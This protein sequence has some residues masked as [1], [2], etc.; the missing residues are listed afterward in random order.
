MNRKKLVLASVAFL[1]LAASLLAAVSAVP[2]IRQLGGNADISSVIPDSLIPERKDGKLSKFGS[3]EEFRK[4]LAEARE[5]QA[6][7]F[8][9]MGGITTREMS[10]MSSDMMTSSK[11]MP[12]VAQNTG[13]AGSVERISGTNVQVAGID[14]PDIV[15]T[16]GASIYFSREP[17][18]DSD[19]SPMPMME[20][21]AAAEMEISMLAP[22]EMMPDV[23]PYRYVPKGRTDIVAALPAD[24]LSK[25]GSLGRSGEMLLFGET[26]VVFDVSRRDIVAFDI[27][28]K[29]DPKEKWMVRN[30]D[31]TELVAA[32][33][34]E[35]MLYLVEKTWANES[36]P[37]PIMP[38]SLGSERISIACTDIYRPAV[39]SGADAVFTAL[40]IDVETGKTKEKTSFVGS[41]GQST[42]YMSENAVYATY[43]K[44]GDRIRY[45]LGFFRE[46]RD[47]LPAGIF[48][49]IEKL[50]DYD[51]GS[52]AKMTELSEILSKL[53][54]GQDQDEQLRF[55][56]EMR[57]R[58]TD[59]AKAHL[60]E[61]ESTGIA[62]LSLPDLSVVADGS[63]PGSLLNQFSLD[64]YQGNL[65][66]ATTVGGRSAFSFGWGGGRE[67]SANDVYVLDADLDREGA[68]LDLG[69]G[70]RIYAARFIGETGYLVTFRETDP[71]YVL[72][73]SDPD[74]PRKAG[75]LKIPGYSS[76][77][78]PLG[79]EMILGIG[80]EEGKVKLSLFDVSLPD[81]P[82]EIS[83][84]LLDEYWSEATQNHHAFLADP[85]HGIFFIP[86][87]QGG[88]VFSYEGN[89]LSLAKAAKD[90]R[91]KRALFIGDV[92]YIV[93]EDTIYSFDEN[94]WEKKGQLDL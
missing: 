93:S 5:S 72:D 91:I 35:N 71:F 25:I 30:G 47:L 36:Q 67:T 92:F 82:R 27:S 58:M 65:R 85:E 11:A 41:S 16:D 4:Y 70:E 32:R 90:D 94:T 88:Y 31:S 49:R 34:Y 77:L 19:E 7:G 62:K 74:E 60:R 17:S 89:E 53:S 83:K 13:G 63:V 28:D 14:E 81:E 43:P 24:T 86:G 50:A 59:Y 42:V 12:S 54:L 73:L 1:V 29:T 68:L 6:S 37:C 18:Y 75:E 8:G 69:L 61:L 84:Y 64:E 48:E 44:Q 39:P 51:I 52:G 10:V 57:N 46:N 21:R 87:S 80:N 78:H 66:V 55:Q 23:V 20:K 38:L 3:D 15:K 26:L 22:G 56:N 2:I 40:S 45:M 33:K 79:K 9:M 76:Y